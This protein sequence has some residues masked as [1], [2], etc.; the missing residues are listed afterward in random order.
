MIGWPHVPNSIPDKKW[1]SD[2]QSCKFNHVSCCSEKFDLLEFL[3]DTLPLKH[4]WNPLRGS[5]VSLG[6]KSITHYPEKSGY[7]I[8]K[9]G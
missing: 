3:V 9:R 4:I 8:V 1:V 5:D 6:M 2:K 7:E